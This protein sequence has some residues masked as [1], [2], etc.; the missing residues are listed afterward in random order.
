M[1]LEYILSKQ[2]GDPINPIISRHLGVL[3]GF[4]LVK[5]TYFERNK[6]VMV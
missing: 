3:I 4:F 1:F 6:Y 2:C 5:M